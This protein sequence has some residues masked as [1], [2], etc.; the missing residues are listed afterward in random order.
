MKVQATKRLWGTR[1]VTERKNKKSMRRVRKA[2]GKW[3]WKG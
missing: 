1:K 2:N 3:K